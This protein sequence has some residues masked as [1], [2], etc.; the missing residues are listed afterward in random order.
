MEI[1]QVLRNQVALSSDEDVIL[2][3]SKNLLEIPNHLMKT[4][5]TQRIIRDNRRKVIYDTDHGLFWN[6]NE[7]ALPK[8]FVGLVQLYSNKTVTTLKD[9]ELI[10]YPIYAVILNFLAFHKSYLIDNV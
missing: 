1:V 9:N 8:K 3:C 7:D 2:T 6:E 10:E 5:F 4:P